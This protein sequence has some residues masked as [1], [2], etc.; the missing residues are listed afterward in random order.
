MLAYFTWNPQR[1]IFKIPYFD[2]PILWYSLLFALGFLLGYLVFRGILKKYFL[3]YPTLNLKEIKSWPLLIE[4]LKNPQTP[5]QIN[6]AAFFNFKSSSKKELFS[7]EASLIDKEAFLKPLNDRIS[8]NKAE[9][10]LLEKAFPGC[11]YTIKEKATFI[12]DKVTVYMVLATIIGARLGQILFYENISFYLKHPLEIFKV[13]QGGLA[14]HGAAAVIILAL[15]ILSRRLKDFRPK[16]SFLNFMDFV[17][18]PT[19]LA[20]VFIR[21]GNFFNQ[22]ILGTETTVPWGVLFLNPLDGSSPAVRHPVQLYEAGFYLFTF[23]V[24]AYLAFKKECFL[25][26]GRLMGL[27]LILV[28]GFRLF[29]EFFKI[30]E[31]PLTDQSSFLMG[32]YLSIPLI[33]LGFFWFFY[34]PQKNQDF[35]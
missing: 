19:A 21:I 10:H 18:A 15:W 28:F 20:A 17:A 33:L 8:K 22:E 4:I 31:S 7:K 30:N 14:S 3:A 25:K 32:Q 13:W 26:K 24:L 12:S 23:L 1:V 11:F 2:F 6:Y 35:T 27:F 16:I 9:R 5:E 34:R 29:I